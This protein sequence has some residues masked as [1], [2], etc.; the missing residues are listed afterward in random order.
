MA[1]VTPARPVPAKSWRQ[2][3]GRFFGPLVR[4]T[5]LFLL[6]ASL[7][8]AQADSDVASS[9]IVSDGKT[10]I[11]ITQLDGDAIHASILAAVAASAIPHRRQIIGMMEAHAPK[12]GE[13]AGITLGVWQ[14]KLRDERLV[15]TY[16]IERTSSH[17]LNYLVQIM[18]SRDVWSAGPVETEEIRSR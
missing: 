14:L 10:S 15:A 9:V 16:R 4:F 12:I 3:A 2:P 7:G 5:L 17:I 1:G 18:R 6:C 13:T 8:M 11:R